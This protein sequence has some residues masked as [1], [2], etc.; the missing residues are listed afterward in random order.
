M[1]SRQLL[2]QVA[3]SLD[4]DHSK[5]ESDAYV[6]VSRRNCFIVHAKVYAHGVKRLRMPA[7]QHVRPHPAD[8]Q[9][10]RRTDRHV[11]RASPDTLHSWWLQH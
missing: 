3:A 10:W 7:D 8:R 4:L 11:R 6:P 2:T 1:Q 9:R 5:F